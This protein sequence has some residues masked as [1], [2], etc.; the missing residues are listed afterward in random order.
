[1]STSREFIDYILENIEDAG[2]VTF[3]KMF[4]EYAVY[5]DGKVIF[6]R[7]VSFL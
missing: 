5:C 2:V 4:G 1:M 3:R 6:N 7:Q